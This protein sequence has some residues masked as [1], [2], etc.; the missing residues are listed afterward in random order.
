MKNKLMKLAGAFGIAAAMALPAYATPIIGSINFTGQVNLT[1]GATFATA[2]FIDFTS[3]QVGYGDGTYTGTASTTT[4]FTDFSFGS[5]PAAGVLPLWSFTKAGTT[6]S[7]DLKT[8]AVDVHTSKSLGLS[9]FGVLHAT[10]FD[11]TFG[12]W[13]FTTQSSKGSLANLSFSADN[14]DVPEPSSIALLAAGL[15][16]ISVMRRKQA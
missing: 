6:Y 4:N 14:A 10:G 13:N 2:T 9:G 8:V 5:F 16:G 12:T 7:F 3:G 15:F 1:G 11:D